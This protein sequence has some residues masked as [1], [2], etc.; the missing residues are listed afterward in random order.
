MPSVEEAKVA[1]SP[2]PA[3]KDEEE[4]VQAI[5]RMRQE[6]RQRRQAVEVAQA[7]LWAQLEAE[8][9]QDSSGPGLDEEQPQAPEKEVEL[10]PHR[11]LNQQ[12]RG[13][14]AREEESLAGREPGGEK[15]GASEK[16]PVP[17]KSRVS[18][19]SSVPET[20]SAPEK[21]LVSEETS[22]SEKSPGPEK[23]SVSEKR[24]IID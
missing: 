12:R 2:P 6:R 1:R 13:P 7:P 15:Q 19:R 17:D 14:W 10:P 18:G 20:A 9:G 22:I 8:E 24:S 16:T 21:R 11:R 23:T 3:S 4:D 5:L